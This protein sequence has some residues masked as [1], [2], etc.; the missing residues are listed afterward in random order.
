M[1][2]NGLSVKNS[3]TFFLLTWLFLFILTGCSISKRDLIGSSTTDVSTQECS[4]ESAHK[5][6]QWYSPPDMNQDDRVPS[7]CETCLAPDNASHNACRVD[8]FIRSSQC[9]GAVCSDS[10]G[11][12]LIQHD[13]SQNFA[14]QHDLRFQNVIKYPLASGESCRFIFWAMEPV[15][16]VEDLYLRKQNNYWKQ[17][18]EASQKLVLPGFPVLNLALGIQPATKRGQHQLHIHIGTLAPGY[19]EAIDALDL[20]PNVTQMIDLNGYKYFVR[21]VPD[22]EAQ[23]AFSGGNPFDVASE[24]IPGAERAMPLYGVLVAIAKN[25]KGIFVLASKNWERSELNFKQSQVCAL[26]KK[27]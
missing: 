26:N 12:F 3:K 11:D 24:I 1:P 2:A 9:S 21:Y 27:Q 4:S 15:V 6:G 23:G 14:L 22:R 7:Q 20:D 13:Q 5:A 10:Q 16:G 8:R 18:F 25:Q 19:R 17:S